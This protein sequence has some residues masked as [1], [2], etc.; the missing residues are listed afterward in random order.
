MPEAMMRSLQDLS[1]GKNCSSNTIIKLAI[2]KF[3]FDQTLKGP[4]A[5]TLEF[6]DVPTDRS[7]DGLCEKIPLDRIV[8]VR[9]TL[10][11]GR[12]IHVVR[13]RKIR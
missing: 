8:S 13:E 10:D 9:Y 1:K 6:G 12:I 7:D 4:Q 3:L 2:A 11:D 5:E